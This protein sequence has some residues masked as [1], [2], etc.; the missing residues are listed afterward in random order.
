MRSQAL[1][2]GPPDDGPPDEGP[3]DEQ[4]PEEQL[5]PTPRRPQVVVRET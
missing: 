4:P 3:P 1:D 2:D 5:C